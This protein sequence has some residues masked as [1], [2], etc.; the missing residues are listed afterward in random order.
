M[1]PISYP[2]TSGGLVDKE[3]FAGDDLSEA[4]MRG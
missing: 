3:T 2:D 1:Y 4:G